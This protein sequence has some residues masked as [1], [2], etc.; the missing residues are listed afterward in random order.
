MKN[1]RKISI[2]LAIVMLFAILVPFTNVRAAA[3]EIKF[4]DAA[5]ASKVQTLLAGSTLA[6]DGLTLTTT[7]TAISELTTLNLAQQATVEETDKIQSLKGVEKLTSL[8]T[9]QVTYNNISDLTPLKNLTGLTTLSIGG[10]NISDL[11]PIKDLT[12]LTALRIGNN[13]ITDLTPIKNFTQLKSLSANTNEISDLTPLAGLTSI[14]GIDLANNNVKSLQPLSGLTTLQRLYVANGDLYINA[15]V[16][17][18]IS[19][20]TPLRGLTNLAELEI[21]NKTAHDRGDA[22][23]YVGNAV[24]D[25]TPIEGILG[26]SVPTKLKLPGNRIVEDVV[27]EETDTEKVVTLPQIFSAAKT[28]G[29][30]VYTT[31]DLVIE[32]GTLS[33]DGTKLTI[34]KPTEATGTA[35][36]KIVG[37]AADA[38]TVAYNLSIKTATQVETPKDDT[39][40]KDDTAAKEKYPQT[41]VNAT[42]LGVIVVAAIGAVT[43]YIKSKKYNG[44]K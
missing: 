7:D 32:N 37:G 14:E 12:N 23:T 1:V 22:G 30:L 20:L 4:G 42:I 26:L 41:G 29:S 8:T 11:T 43:V 15:N 27:F 10:N 38:T 28:E 6:A 39:A 9:L 31:E 2:V 19:D 34:K 24:K 25:I 40:T 16:R 35:S 3:V 13:K 18:E 44:L 36:V 21:G 17:N 5:V 33:A